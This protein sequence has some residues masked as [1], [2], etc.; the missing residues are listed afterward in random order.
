MTSIRKA[1]TSDKD[2]ILKVLH[3]ADEY[4]PGITI[5]NFWVHEDSGKITGVVQFKDYDKYYFLSGLAVSPSLWNKGIGSLLVNKMIEIAK[6][7]P[8]K[9]IYL[10]SIKPEY[11]TRFG[12]RATTETIPLPVKA[13][14]QCDDCFPEK[15]KFMK[16]ENK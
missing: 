11:F 6:R 12:F 16:W 2:Q 7:Y 14:H 1:T 8:G 13:P 9:H 15:C 3:D 10:N 4:Y 5:E